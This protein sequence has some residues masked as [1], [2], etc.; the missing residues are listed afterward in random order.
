MHPK[1]FSRFQIDLVNSLAK[2]S[3]WV[4]LAEG[5]K[6]SAFLTEGAI[7]SSTPSSGSSYSLIVCPCEYTESNLNYL[8]V[9]YLSFMLH[10]CYVGVKLTYCYRFF[11]A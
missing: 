10:I 4:W 5:K 2:V 11:A 3:G 1:K 9:T 7:S 6:A 8:N